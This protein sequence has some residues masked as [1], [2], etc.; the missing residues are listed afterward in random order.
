MKSYKG[1]GGYLA[2]RSR[3]AGAGF[4]PPGAALV[5]DRCRERLGKVEREVRQV[6]YAKANT[7][8]PS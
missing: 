4:K 6:C 5:E 8:E 7:R 3:P 1:D 2:L